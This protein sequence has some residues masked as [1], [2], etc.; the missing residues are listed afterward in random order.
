MVQLMKTF[1]AYDYEL[2]RKK[3][4]FLTQLSALFFPLH[5]QCNALL[6]FLSPQLFVGTMPFSIESSIN[7]SRRGV[8]AA[9]RVIEIF[10]RG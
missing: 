9:K 4:I 3:N 8:S 7:S 1:S 6:F 5:F 10:S 2:R